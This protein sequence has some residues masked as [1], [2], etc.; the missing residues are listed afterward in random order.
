MPY[1][2][3]NSKNI[4]RNF[5]KTNPESNFHLFETSS[6][7]IRLIYNNQKNPV[8]NDE[9]A[10]TYNLDGTDPYHPP[11]VSHVPYGFIELYGQNVARPFNSSTS[12]PDFIHPFI[13]KD[14][15][16]QS[17]ASVSTGQFNSDFSYGDRID[18][19]GVRGAT[20]SSQLVS[21]GVHVPP[22]NSLAESS[23]EDTE[24]H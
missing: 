13:T 15:G 22:R 23:D 8:I 4:V 16:L 21:S 3:L 7:Q 11:N 1:Y 6:S 19:L 5:L 20:I 18:G 14:S 12:K 10:A 2:R 9:H 24:M 17:M